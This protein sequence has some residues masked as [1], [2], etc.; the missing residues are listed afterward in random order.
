M[1]QSRTRNPESRSRLSF[2]SVDRLNKRSDDELRIKKANSAL[3]P[4]TRSPIHKQK[5]QDNFGN[6]FKMEGKNLKIVNNNNTKNESSN[7]TSRDGTNGPVEKSK[8]VNLPLPNIG[9][10]TN[11]I[12]SKRTYETNPIVSSRA[13]SKPASIK[14]A[15]TNLS[16]SRDEQPQIHVP[17][18]KER[19]ERN[20]NRLALFMAS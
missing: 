19:K 12:D 7:K 15:G 20:E 13:A 17:S 10:F 1:M 2:K 8:P 4:L 14:H 16:K 3:T 11:K 9:M 6:P 18:I 5:G